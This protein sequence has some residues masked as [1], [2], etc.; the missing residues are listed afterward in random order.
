MADD[1]ERW[2][3]RLRPGREIRPACGVV[4]TPPSPASCD[5]PLRKRGRPPSRGITAGRQPSATTRP[6]ATDRSSRPVSAPEI[7]WYQTKLP[8]PVRHVRGTEPPRALQP[9]S[10]GADHRGGAGEG[11]IARQLLSGRRW[12]QRC[13]PCP[14]GGRPPP[15]HRRP[16]PARRPSAVR[17]DPGRARPRVPA[18]SLRPASAG[19]VLSRKESSAA[20]KAKRCPLSVTR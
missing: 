4:A 1:G 8:K 19:A 9:V 16:P 7:P 11:E 12:R 10:V 14:S 13:S 3:G 5:A 6:S 17:C 18:C 2:A 20:K 15:P